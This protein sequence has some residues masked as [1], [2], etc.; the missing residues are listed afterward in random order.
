MTF[1]KS[2]ESG[3][4]IRLLS[5]EAIRLISENV[6]VGHSTRRE[7]CDAGAPGACAVVMKRNISSTYSIINASVVDSEAVSVS[8]SISREKDESTSDETSLLELSHA[9]H[10]LANMLESSP[11][12]EDALLQVGKFDDE[13][14]S[15]Q[16]TMARVCIQFFKSGG[17]ES[18]LWLASLPQL[19][20]MSNSVDS[21]DLLLV[22]F[23][24]LAS[25]CPLL[26]SRVATDEGFT[27]WAE[28]ILSSL[29]GVL[30][31]NA[32]ADSC[33]NFTQELHINALRGIYALAEYEPLKFRIMYQI[34]PQLLQFKNDGSRTSAKSQLAN[35]VCMALGF[36]EDVI[37]QT[38]LNDPKLF[39]DWF[40]LEHSL[41]IQ[42]MVRD[43]IRSALLNAWGDIIKILNLDNSQGTGNRDPSNSQAAHTLLRPLFS[44]ISDDESTSDL[45]CN[46]LQ[47][48]A[49]IYENSALSRADEIDTEHTNDEIYTIQY[50]KN[51]DPSNALVSCGL[52]ENVDGE[53]VEADGDYF[54]DCVHPF[55]MRCSATE[56][57]WIMAHRQAILKKSTFNE[58]MTKTL[59]PLP[60]RVQ[61]LLD[62][63]FPSPLIQCDTIPLN[64][65]R[66][67]ASFNFRALAMPERRY[68]SFRRESQILSRIYEK[69]ASSLELEDAYWTL[70]FSNSKFAGEFAETL[71]QALYRCPVI[72]SISFSKGPTSATS[73]STRRSTS[74]STLG[75]DDEYGST[76]LAYI[77]GSLPPWV[78]SLTYDNVLDR[79]AINA[80]V[81][82]L[83][84]IDQRSSG[85][86]QSIL[87]RAQGRD[88]HSVSS[89]SSS[90]HNVGVL[91]SFAIRN[92]P[93]LGG[94]TLMPFFQFL[95]RKPLMSLR[96]LDLS[97]N[98]LGDSC[99]AAV[100]NI[101]FTQTP[102]SALERLDLSRNEIRHGVNV[103]QVIRNYVNQH[104]S[105]Q[106]MSSAGY[107]TWCSSLTTLNLS[108]NE[109]N[110]GMVAAEIV[111][112]LRNNVLTLKSLNISRNGL[113]GERD[114]LIRILIKS[115]ESNTMLLDLD[116]SENEFSHRSIDHL[117]QKLSHSTKDILGMNFLQLHG[118]KP[119]LLSSHK[120]VLDQ[121]LTKAKEE[122]V[123][124][125]FMDKQKQANIYIEDG[126]EDSKA[127]VDHINESFSDSI[128][129][130]T[131]QESRTNGSYSHDE[132]S[133]TY[134]TSDDGQKWS[135]KSEN[136]N[137]SVPKERAKITVLFS[138]P[139][140][141][142]DITN[143][144]RPI[145]MLSFKEEK[146]LLWQCFKEV[147]LHSLH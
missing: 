139:L 67:D 106:L 133:S 44:N 114:K 32:G 46:M 49:N 26:L 138:A 83:K 96:V 62:T 58:K 59:F 143:K 21:N 142:K 121:L 119:K 33:D 97:G 127:Q 99:C 86:P 144:L 130:R 116:L 35:Q 41:I 22:S 94:D 42:A 70:G 11:Q 111:S 140:V 61:Q 16:N 17:I 137:K 123:K 122:R 60:V 1:V 107:E 53:K 3:E 55:P 91:Q 36:N 147:S 69:Y 105:N 40:C 124:R 27:G 56:S 73:L 6:T 102:Q 51:I 85:S 80:L 20:C 25:L 110:C 89:V 43:E 126:I 88:I 129:T 74:V 39:F 82:I 131:G 93:Q 128:S 118:N 57:D 90:G 2:D 38:S 71:V 72:Q 64:D 65:F 19:N 34:F 5:I 108:C 77:A 8:S 87:N 78:T 12:E 37:S 31:R 54:I 48:Y 113:T 132:L 136:E 76:L 115:L 24:S 135:Y 84:T 47:Q 81:K 10:A 145:E 18:L 7:L 75:D 13:F 45:R 23:R 29:T 66:P 134:H 100:L 92:N 79:N 117:L 146:D 15:S 52:A 95:G 14:L 112:L 68:F 109:L 30:K 98:N 141:W 28:D 63:Y 104:R 103:I 50:S 101:A 125:Y 120:L 4:S 9:L